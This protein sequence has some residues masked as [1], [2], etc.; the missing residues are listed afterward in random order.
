ML[1]LV[2]HGDEADPARETA[3]G[4]FEALENEERKKGGYLR[5]DTIAAFIKKKKLKTITQLLCS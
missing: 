3:D 5:Y 4:I 2:E 1:N